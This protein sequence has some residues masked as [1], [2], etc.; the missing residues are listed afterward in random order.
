MKK[1]KGKLMHWNEA[2]D[3]ISPFDLSK[4]TGL[5]IQTCRK[6]FDSHNFPAI[7]KKLVGNQGLADKEAVRLY[8]QG[9]NIT[10]KDKNGLLVLIYQ[11]LKK[12]NK[13]RDEQDDEELIN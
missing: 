13:K 3:I 11:E 7:S 5:G 8:L 4:I 6:M 10:G 1:K 2:P 9:F 12:I